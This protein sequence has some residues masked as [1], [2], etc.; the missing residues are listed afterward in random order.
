MGP[1]DVELVR[2]FARRSGATVADIAFPVNQPI[3]IVVEAEAGAAIIGSGT[4][5][6]TNIVV[7]DLSVFQI[8]P[9]A[10]APGARP[11]TGNLGTAGQWPN[12]DQVFRLTVAAAALAGRQNHICQV[13]AWLKVRIS[14]PDMSF[15]VSPHF[16]LTTP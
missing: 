9:S 15:A 16:I 11:L 8:I 4:D 2:A 12:R 14:D 3:E 7:Q 10:V 6:A 1:N 5:Y 13:I